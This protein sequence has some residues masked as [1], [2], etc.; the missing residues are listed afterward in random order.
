[1]AS[2]CRLPKTSK[3]YLVLLPAF[4]LLIFLG[5]FFTNTSTALAANPPASK[6]S[7]DTFP[8]HPSIKPNV[9]FW[10]SI[11][12]KY[13]KKQGVIH[14]INHLNIVYEIIKLDPSQTRTASRNNKKRIK[15]AYAKYKTILLAL[16]KKK[17]GLTKEELRIA[18]LFKPNTSSKSFK[19]AAFNIRCQT[20]L[21]KQFKEGLVR[22]GS[23]IE[24][25]KRI[26][27][28]HGLPT[29][30][31]YLPCVESSFN[32]KAYS[33]FGAAGIWQFTRSTGKQYMTVGYVVDERRDP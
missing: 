25:F 32:F 24:E 15:S 13:S 16:S 23:V 30:L 22:S 8:M 27:K 5:V 21:K 20:G 4:F 1:M 19:N 11:F 14:D 7:V 17:T 3:Y 33:K 9:D 29:D 12:T 6:I 26:F 10:I 2:A 28:S 18:A 31:T